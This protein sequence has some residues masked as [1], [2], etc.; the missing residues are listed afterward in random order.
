MADTFYLIL[1]PE[2]HTLDDPDFFQRRT[3]KANLPTHTG[4]RRTFYMHESDRNVS[5]EYKNIEINGIRN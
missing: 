2:A 4:P 5:C 1:P 3:L